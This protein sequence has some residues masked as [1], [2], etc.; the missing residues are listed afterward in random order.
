[1][2]TSTDDGSNWKTVGNITISDASWKEYTVTA[3]VVGDVRVRFRRTQGARMHFDD[4]TITDYSSG[5]SDPTAERHLWNAYSR[6]GELIVNIDKA[7]G[8]AIGIYTVAGV[9]LFEGRLSQGNYSWPLERGT[10]VLVSSGDF[11]RTVL[12]R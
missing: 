4:V 7:E 8:L 2:E 3:N 5:V 10:F 11:T 1:M 9:T 12:I 6:G